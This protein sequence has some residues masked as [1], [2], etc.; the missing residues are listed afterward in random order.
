MKKRRVRSSLAKCYNHQ[1]RHEKYHLQMGNP[2]PVTTYVFNFSFL[3]APHNVKHF[4][5]SVSVTFDS[6]F[7]YRAL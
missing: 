1:G 5:R 7:C 2:K 4:K 6:I 3:I